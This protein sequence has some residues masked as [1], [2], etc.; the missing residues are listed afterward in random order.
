MGPH[1]CVPWRCHM[2][3]ILAPPPSTPRAAPDRPAPAEPV[4]RPLRP[5]PSALGVAL[6]VLGL[7]HLA[8]VPGALIGN[9]HY[10]WNGYV[11]DLPLLLTWPLGL[12]LLAYTLL[13]DVRASFRP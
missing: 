11:G 12:L 1:R 8:L 2:S 4:E 10:G 9:Q 5:A 3:T 13:C 6:L 7:A